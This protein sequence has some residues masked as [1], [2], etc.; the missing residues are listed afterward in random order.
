MV[1]TKTK[2]DI[3]KIGSLNV[4]DKFSVSK[5]LEDE[6]YRVSAM[7]LSSQPEYIIGVGVE[8]GCRL[9]WGK[10]ALV[11]VKVGEK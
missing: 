4:G 9:G 7:R 2:F 5:E 10:D 8:T 3:V 1:D 6:Q 11:Y